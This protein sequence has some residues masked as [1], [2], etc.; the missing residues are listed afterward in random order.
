MESTTERDKRWELVQIECNKKY[1][2][3]LTPLPVYPHKLYFTTVMLAWF[4]YALLSFRAHEFPEKSETREP[5]EI[6]MECTLYLK[7]LNNFDS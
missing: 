5:V 7:Y 1:D 6:I 2:I 3:K 4:A